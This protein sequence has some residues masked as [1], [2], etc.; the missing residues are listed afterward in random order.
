MVFET[1]VRLILRNPAASLLLAVVLMG[2]FVYAGKNVRLNNQFAELFAVDNDDN[3]YREFYRK[4]FGADDGLLIAI[5]QPE[6]V[7]DAFFSRVEKL[8]RLFEANTYFSRVLSP[9]SSSV[10]WSKGDDVFID[11]LFGGFDEGLSLQQKLTLL[12]QS[13]NTANHLVSTHSNTFLLIAE[14]PPKYDRYETIKVPAEYFRHEVDNTFAE[15]NVKVS[16]AGIAFTRKGILDLMMNDLF[17]LV[18]LTAVA[19]ALFSW[20]MFRSGFVIWVTMLTMLFSISGAVGVIGL[21]GDDINQLTITLPVLLMVIVVAGGIHFFHRYFVEVAHGKTVE[22]AAFISA[23]RVGKGAFLSAFTTMIGFYSL[24]ISDMPILRSFGFYLGTGVLISFV[25]MIL[26]IP[27]CLQLFPPGSG[28]H[29]DET[30]FSWV[31]NIVA[32]CVVEPGR[33]RLI[34]FGM[35]LTVSAVYIASK[36]QYDYVLSDMLDE[37]HPQ[38]KAAEILN[39]EMTGAL[40][41]EVSLLGKPDAFLKSANLQ[42]MDTLSQWLES[43]GIGKDN[44]SLASVIKSL[45]N[46]VTHE[47]RV[48]DNDDAISQL[49]ILVEGSPD[50]ILEQLVS[51]DY[52][53]ARIKA[54]SQDIGAKNLVAFQKEFNKYAKNLFAG[55][56]IAVRLSGEIPVAYNG[57]NRLTEELLRSVA[58]AMLLIVFTIFVVFRNL[59]MALGSIFP[60]ILPIILGLAIYALSGVGLNPLPG[61]AFCIA[62]GIAV[63]DTVHLFSRFEEE[64]TQGVSRQ[65]AILSAMKGVKGALIT[66]SIILTVG[67]LMF[68]FSGFTWNRQ[69]GWLGAFLIVTAL[70]ADLVFT[71]AILS[72]ERKRT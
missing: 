32:K 54:N 39:K 31:D 51:D 49:L 46:A 30:R 2:L 4:Q 66:S 36:A 43:Q 40:P 26:I 52:S 22:E 8:T 6:Q 62:I 72:F 15:S 13:P 33:K 27:T 21:N 24:L 42:K 37:N 34:V 68:I 35:I 71:P 50:N 23:A 18:P 19:I 58:S 61:I 11:P 14:M 1:I 48:P 56:G 65:Q 53:H 69:L 47:N 28:K 20:W 17:M 3:A 38:V 44:L 29:G 7:T 67:F 25:G 55:T 70:L 64:Y 60:N 16:Y 63:D 9:T 10:I 5:L 12:R 41:I 45:N 59:Q 57:M